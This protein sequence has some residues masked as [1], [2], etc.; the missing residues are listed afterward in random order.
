MAKRQLTNG[1]I[2]EHIWDC[3]INISMTHLPCEASD[4]ELLVL[5]G[6]K[7]QV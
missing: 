4:E 6:W 3:T 1:K 2:N 5:W 7:S